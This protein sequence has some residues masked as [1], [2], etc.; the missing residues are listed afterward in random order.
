MAKFARGQHALSISDRSGQAFPYLEMVREWTG[1]WVHISEYE[2]KSPL[3][4]PKPVGAD[5]QAVQRA[6]PARTE[7]YT[8]TI[9]PNNPLSTAGSTTVTVNDPNHGRS[10]GDAVRFRSVISYVGGVSPII[11]ML[12][13]TLASDLTDSATTLTLSDASAF[14]TS[15]YIVVNP[16]ANDSETIKYTGKSS[17]DLTGLTRGSSAPTYNLTPLVTTASAHSSGVQVRGSYSITKVDA[18]SYTFT[19]ASAASTTE[20]GGGFPIFAGPVNARA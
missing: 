10:T 3:I 9:L 7:F 1:A 4:Q 8:P 11:F 2:P 14:P 5:P 15:G 19:L 20:T 17:N 6:R 13:T 12:E 18:D 16:G